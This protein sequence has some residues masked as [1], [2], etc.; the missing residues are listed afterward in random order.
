MDA[1]R[2]AIGKKVFHNYCKIDFDA[3]RGYLKISY[4]QDEERLASPDRESA[5]HNIDL[6]SDLQEM[7]FHIESESDGEE[8][9]SSFLALNVKK[10]NTNGLTKL[11]NCYKPDCSDPS[12]RYIVIEFRNDD[13]FRKLLDLF[14]SHKYTEAL[15]NSLEELPARQAKEYCQALFEDSEKAKKRRFRV[16]LSC[17]RTGFLEGKVDTD[18][19]LHYPF[20]YHDQTFI[21]LQAKGLRYELSEVIGVPSVNENLC[22][23][24]VLMN[25]FGPQGDSESALAIK[26]SRF[27]LQVTVADF[28]RLEPGEYLNDTL[29]DFW[30]H[31]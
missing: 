22:E 11:S 10:S 29:I 20:D 30:L 16:S 26:K 17:E 5:T 24:T 19:L 23:S 8:D 2:I 14:R 15:V 7:K 28:E 9:L 25:D 6:I 12:K 13:D 18:V 21:D 31:W 3:D 27:S 4:R 1:I